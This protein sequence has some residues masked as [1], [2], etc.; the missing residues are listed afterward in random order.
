MIHDVTI[1]FS[2]DTTPIENQIA[3]IGEQEVKNIIR[4]VTLNGIYS[5]MPSKRHGYYGGKL[6][7]TKD[8]EVDWKAYVDE[9]MYNWLN[10]HKQEVIDEAAL[11]IAMR[12]GRT[13]Q[14]RKVLEELKAER[15]AQ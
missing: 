1:P 9:R 11:L 7:P 13:T 3:N 10:I 12:A 15:D 2:F 8:G 5:A 4:E 14:W 6:T